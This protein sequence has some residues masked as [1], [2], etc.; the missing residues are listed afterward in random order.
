MTKIN[1]EAVK[2][3]LA[4]VSR[5]KPRHQIPE[6]A[7]ILGVHENTVRNRLKKKKRYTR[8]RREIASNG[9]EIAIELSDEEI[10][11]GVPLPEFDDNLLAA[12]REH[13]GADMPEEFAA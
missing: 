11:A 3:A 1:A 10:A 2:F 9:V 12:L 5:L 7:R 6:A 13:M 8:R 4:S